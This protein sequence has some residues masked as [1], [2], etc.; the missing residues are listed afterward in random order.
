MTIFSVSAGKTAETT[1]DGDG[2]YRFE[3]LEPGNYRIESESRG[4]KRSV[5]EGVVVSESKETVADSSLGIGIEVTVDVVANV[6]L[7]VGEAMGGVMVS[8]D[9]STPL[10]KAVANEDIEEVRNLIIKG[11]NVNGKDENYDKITPLFIAVEHGN[12]EITRLLLDFG[13]KINA[14]DGSKQ[15]PLMRLD[16]DATPEL[17][18]LLFQHGAK[19]NLT[20]NEG[21]TALI[22]VA[23][24][25][26]PEVLQAL[27]DA[28]ADVNLA[29]NEGQTALMNA[30]GSDTLESIRHLLLAGA[31]VNVK[32]KEGDSAWDLTSDQEVEDLLVSFGADIKVKKPAEIISSGDPR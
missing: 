8:A 27:I 12:V 18:G 13:A 16:D 21:N 20:D 10:A 1:T 24:S 19:V 32:N 26:K 31:K 15:T 4:F 29:N 2:V 23:G 3:N 9:Y 28:G 14:R 6:E 7:Q 11:A 17:A 5:I 25:V 22:V 30:A